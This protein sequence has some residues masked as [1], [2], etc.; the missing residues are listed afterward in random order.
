MVEKLVGSWVG[1]TVAEL[2]VDL[3]VGLAV[4]WV[5]AMA[6]L[7]VDWWV[8]WKAE[9]MVVEQCFVWNGNEDEFRQVLMSKNN[10][11]LQ[12]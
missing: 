4:K 12:C 8:D 9:K 11:L 1:S 5:D 3:A 2:V 6:G 10:Y 7:T